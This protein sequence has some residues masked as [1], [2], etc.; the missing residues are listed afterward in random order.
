MKIAT[1]TMNPTIDMN[2]DVD[3]VLA[4]HKLRCGKPQFEPGGGGINVSRAIRNLG[5]DSIALLP[6]GGPNGDL[7]KQLLSGEKI[8]FESI[9]I[10]EHTRLNI[11]I[12]EESSTKQY[13][14]IMPGPEL[15]ENEWKQCLDKV[16][17]LEEKPDYIVIS[18][19]LPPG[20]PKDIF[21]TA[22]N[23]GKEIN[24]KVIIDSKKISLSC[25]KKCGVFMI[26]PNLREFQQLAGTEAEDDAQIEASTKKIIKEGKIK[27]IIISMGAGGAMMITQNECKHFRS[28]TVPIKSKVGAGDCMT[29]GIVYSLAQGRSLAD[30][31]KFGVAAGAAAVMTPG[32]ELC[33]KEDTEKLYKRT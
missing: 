10:K 31:V 20:V 15:S 11:N 21:E 7:L 19:S 27:V 26:K 18:G 16:K 6:V 8:N 12:Y 28:P 9:P 22:A 24:A 33:K 4:E 32:T 1:L 2:S 30:A 5:G 29:A 3:Q 23:I 25:L 13:R 14:F 17:D